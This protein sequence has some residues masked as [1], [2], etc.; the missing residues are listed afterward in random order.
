MPIL[1][2]NEIDLIKHSF[3]KYLLSIGFEE[4]LVFT[5]K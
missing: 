5:S 4:G 3:L 2:Y 1:K